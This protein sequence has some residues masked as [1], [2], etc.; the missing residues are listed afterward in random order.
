MTIQTLDAPLVAPGE[1]TLLNFDNA[2]PAPEDGMHVCLC[3]NV[4]GTNFVMWFDQDMSF[5]FTL[6]LRPTPAS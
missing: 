3:N 5:H 6:A 2:K 4:W 1:R